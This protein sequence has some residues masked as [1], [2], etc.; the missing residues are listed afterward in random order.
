MPT[1]RIAR[2]LACAGVLSLIAVPSP[3][4]EPRV[5]APAIDTTPLDI[6]PR[7][8]NPR[9]FVREIQRRADA[10]VG[11]DIS[12][13][14]QV[15]PIRIR[16]VVQLDS[17]VHEARIVLSSGNAAVDSAAVQLVRQTRFVPGERHGVPVPSLTTQPLRF[18]FPKE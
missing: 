11:D 15:L 7:M 12:L 17:S 3:A 5:Q 2:T 4:Q 8:A 1:L 13:E 18:V 16:F 6:L 9:A 14:G 10:L